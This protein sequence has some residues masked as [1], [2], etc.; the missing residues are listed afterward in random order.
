MVDRTF[1]DRD[2]WRIYCNHLTDAERGV[3]FIEFMESK[4]D[5]GYDYD[6]CRTLSNDIEEFIGYVQEFTGGGS[7]EYTMASIMR[8]AIKAY[9]DDVLVS[10]ANEADNFISTWSRKITLRDYGIPDESRL[11]ILDDSLIQDYPNPIERAEIVHNVDEG[12]MTLMDAMG[13]VVIEPVINW[14][15]DSPVREIGRSKDIYKS[16][17]LLDVATK[18]LVD[19]EGF[20]LEL[21]GIYK[22]CGI[23]DG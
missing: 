12:V 7:D 18:G 15:D 3:F 4:G 20:L 19:V 6:P 8:G 22:E 9:I 13:V 11:K 17:D 14:W 10:W 1:S 2:L 16:F 5:C 21:K 23:E